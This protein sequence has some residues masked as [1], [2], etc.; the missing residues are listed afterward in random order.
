MTKLGRTHEATVGTT[1]VTPSILLPT[2]HLVR[3]TQPPRSF[4]QTKNAKDY[5]VLSWQG[6]GQRIARVIHRAYPESVY[7][8]NLNDGTCTCCRPQVVEGPCC[9]HL[10]TS[11]NTAQFDLTHHLKPWDT[12][13]RLRAQYEKAMAG[14]TNIIPPSTADLALMPK[15]PL[16]KPAAVPRKPGRPADECRQMSALEMATNKNKC[17]VCGLYGH[18]PGSK[19]CS[20]FNLNPVAVEASADAAMAAPDV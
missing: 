7:I 19:K 8:A 17:K 12:T 14:R 1:T 15:Q 10:T 13:A 3:P 16:K 11:A 9:V 4:P 2:A 20:G 6:F 18:K 5:E